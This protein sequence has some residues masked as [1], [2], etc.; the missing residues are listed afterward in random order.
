M[1]IDTVIEERA[2]ESSEEE[3]APKA[4]LEMAVNLSNDSTP[5][6]YCGYTDCIAGPYK[7]RRGWSNHY[8][9]AHAGA[10]AEGNHSIVRNQEPAPRKVACPHCGKKLLPNNLKRHVDEACKVLRGRERVQVVTSLARARKSERLNVEKGKVPAQP[11]SADPLP[12]FRGDSYA[13]AIAKALPVLIGV[14][15]IPPKAHRELVEWMV[16]TSNLMASV[17]GRGNQ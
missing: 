10:A 8:R 2:P 12:V 13:D 7:D 17:Y 3:Q 5:Q 6:W 11:L 9:S 1:S 16:A 4:P 14:Q 15:P